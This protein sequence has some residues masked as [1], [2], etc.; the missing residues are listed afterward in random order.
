M[1]KLLLTIGERVRSRRKKLGI[2]RAVLAERAGVSAR[3][4]AQLEGGAGNISIQRLADVSCALRL[5]LSMLVVG[6]G[7]QPA[8]FIGLVGLRGAGKSTVGVALAAELGWQ[9][10][11]LD[12]LIVERAGL[13]L[14]EIFELGGGEYYRSL[15]KEVLQQVSMRTEST[16]LAAGGSIVSSSE[17]WTFLRQMARTVWLYAK[18]EQYLE[19]VQAQGDLR[20]MKGHSDALSELQQILNARQSAYA[21]SELHVDTDLH[22]VD[23]VVMLI[24]TEFTP[25]V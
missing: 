1:N 9:F 7:Y 16:V 19:R 8:S 10:V 6:L 15:E 14:A 24:K 12:H 18:P 5:P 11:E 13:S 4:L 22:D 2:S 25:V 20:P 3:F 17:N 23:D 21:Q